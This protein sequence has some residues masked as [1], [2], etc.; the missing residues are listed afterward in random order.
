MKTIMRSGITKTIAFILILACAAM[1]AVVCMDMADVVTGKNSYGFELDFDDSSSF[2]RAKADMLNALTAITP[3][4]AAKEL[5]GKGY[6]YSITNINV[7]ESYVNGIDPALEDYTELPYW[8]R[9]EK[10]TVQISADETGGEGTPTN[11]EVIVTPT[12]GETNDFV[13]E[14]VEIIPVARADYVDETGTRHFFRGDS[15]YTWMSGQW[16]SVETDEWREV[17][18]DWPGE[19]TVYVGMP[20]EMYD[21]LC[22]NWVSGRKSA[23]T[24]LYIIIGVAVFALLLLIYLMWA[25]GRK[26]GDDEVHTLLIDRLP[27]ELTAAV[28]IGG[29]LVI[30]FLCIEPFIEAWVRDEAILFPLCAIGI[31]AAT[32]LLVAALLSLVRNIK[33]RTFISRLLSLKIVKLLWKIIVKIFNLTIK[34]LRNFFGGLARFAS[35]LLGH[36][37]SIGVMVLFAAY[38][39]VTAM[40]LSMRMLFAPIVLWAGAEFVLYR[41]LSQADKIQDGIREI[42]AGNTD[43]RIE[44]CTSA[45]LSKTAD[46]LNSIGEAVKESVD[47]EVKAQRMKNE[48]ITNVSHD[49][50]TPLT[51]IISYADLLASMNLTPKEA[52]DYAKI[53]KQKG[54]QLKKLTQ[55]LFDISKAESGSETVETENLDMALL[56]RQSLA[57]LHSEIDGSGLTFVTDI[58]ET[59]VHISGDGKKLSRVFE[60]LLVNAIKY[61]M[62]GTRVYVSLKA[63]DGRA[64]AEIKN[65]SAEPMNFDPAEITE[66]FV[67][68][69]QS[70]TTEGS[71]LGLAIARSYTELCGGKLNVSVDGDLF[72]AVVVFNTI[73]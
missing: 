54:D 18:L 69:D 26:N 71:G 17:Y 56:L 61:S 2:L 59:E 6:F 39:L 40:L 67:R 64:E 9:L 38:F 7:W 34:I 46:S 25:S 41:W 16:E 28:G 50:K 15:E 10:K 30:C 65:I 27:P 55:D 42:R 12:D 33:N 5:E 37:I 52:N 24:H 63:K 48:L 72:K 43:H 35:Y 31:T 62:A 66:R 11:P 36:K 60:N 22:V 20:I 58:P 21:E 57:E 29:P 13:V 73:K 70:R 68:G 47:R 3:E 53:V 32:A 49:L 44:G 19:W 14:P 1:T 8:F 51:S 4:M 45:L 23:L